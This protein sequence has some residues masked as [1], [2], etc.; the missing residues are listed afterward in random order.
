MVAWQKRNNCIQY[1]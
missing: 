1:M